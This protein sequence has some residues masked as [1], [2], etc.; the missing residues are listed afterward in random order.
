MKR[1]IAIGIVGVLLG[2]GEQAPS[3]PG[4]R[5]LSP[6]AATQ[7]GVSWSPDGKRIAYWA[8]VADS[9]LEFQLWVAHADLSAPVKL[10]VTARQRITN[11]IPASWSPDGTQLAAYSTQFGAGDVV[12]APAAGG[13]ARRITRGQGIFFNGPWNHD[14]D[15]VEVIETA[16]GGTFR[17]SAFS[18]SEGTMV[19]LVP[20]E[21]HPYFAHLSPDGSHIL[22]M[23]ID[24]PRSTLWV[25]DSVG[26]HPRQL[27]TEGFEAFPAFG[28]SQSWSPDG[29]EILYESR[30]TGTSDLWIV[31]IAGGTPRQ[32]THDVR[33]DYNG[34]WSSDGK[35]VAFVS[36]RGRQL[37]V[38]VIPSAGGTE[39]RVTDTPAE[40]TE[41]PRFRP[42]TSELAFIGYTSHSGVWA[43]DVADGKETR[44]TPDTLRTSWFDIAPD[45]KQFDFVIERGGSIQ[46]LAVAPVT[47]GTIRML[48]SGGGSVTTPFWSPTGSKIAFASD[49][50][51]A[52]DIFVVDAAGGPLKQLEKWPGY[53]G[54][55]AWGRDDSWIYFIS[56]RDAKLSDVWKVSPAGGEPVRVT[57]VGAVNSLYGR[58]GVDA[59]YVTTFGQRSG[60]FP[61]SRI[62]PDGSL[63][64][65][66]DK[67]N[68]FVISIS[69]RGDSLVMVADQ[70]N[71]KTTGMMMPASGGQ[72]RI[73]LP[74]SELPGALSEDARYMVY[75]FR[76]N[77]ANHIGIVTLATGAKRPLTHAADEDAA[78]EWT[79]DGKQILF[80]RNHNVA[81]IFVA[82]LSK[83]FAA[84]K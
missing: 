75:Q 72:G 1:V 12:I 60:V 82:D 19:P 33:N 50:A 68:S 70:P 13:S 9:A 44:L 84:H 47:G 39:T 41:T 28:G 30:R 26:E 66:W 35:W 57:R 46:D 10:P 52:G 76:A 8:P 43:V 79:P 24:G 17:T 51:G 56:D 42:G 29:K 11:A 22:Y 34:T 65:V 58:R 16:E 18:L 45:G 83:Q 61:T 38:W 3:L 21:T 6:D 77:G 4:A 32:L 59:L 55:V 81:R 36:D 54:P 27:T 20:H 53:E 49:R 67:S 7:F 62:E 40:E 78:A 64:T 15:K 25:A 80:E 37:D 5:A 71:G 14:G 74:P 63:H 2:C 48:T 31:P 69:P 23:Q 73:L